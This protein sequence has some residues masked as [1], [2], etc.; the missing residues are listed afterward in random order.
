MTEE[1]FDKI[2]DDL[3]CNKKAMLRSRPYDGQV[4][5][6]G[7]ER[8]KT[9]IEGITFR[10]LKDCFVRAVCLSASQIRDDLYMESTL[11]EHARISD[12]DLYGWD[13][14]ELDPIAVAQNLN[15]EV[16]KIM[17][18][19]PNVPKLEVPDD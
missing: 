4:H 11:G 15:C 17:G 12:N 3:G 14:N 6:A 10:D 7:G 2:F 18:I 8:G 9:M 16:E 1:F 19:F 5:T 13:L